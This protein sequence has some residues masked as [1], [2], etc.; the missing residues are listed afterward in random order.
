MANVLENIEDNKEIFHEML[1]VQVSSNESFHFNFE[2]HGFSD[3]H[4]FVVLHV[5]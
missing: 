2:L 4:L 3:P 1:I 5:R